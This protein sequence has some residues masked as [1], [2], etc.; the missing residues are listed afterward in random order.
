MKRSHSLITK[1]CPEQESMAFNTPL[2]EY[3]KDAPR[4]CASTKWSLPVT[5]NFGTNEVLMLVGGSKAT[6]YNRLNPKSPYYDPAYPK[7]IKN[8]RLSIYLS[9]EV[10]AYLANR[11]SVRDNDP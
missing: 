3:V 1:V 9:S 11:V 6:H 5:K 10:T 8:G 7:P 4:A 2:L